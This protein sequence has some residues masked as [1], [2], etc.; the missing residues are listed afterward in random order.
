MRRGDHGH[1]RGHTQSPEYRVWRGMIQNTESP[2][3]SSWRY[4]ARHG[5]KVCDRWRYSFQSFLIDMGPR[6]A[7]T[8]LRRLDR[9]ADF[10]PDN[11]IWALVKRRGRRRK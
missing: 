4:Y 11:C 9:S 7:N 8:R 1:C 10:G 5:V 2:R 3:S 6:P